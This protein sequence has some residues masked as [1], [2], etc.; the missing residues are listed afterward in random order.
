MNDNKDIPTLE[1]FEHVRS[2]IRS[3]GDYFKVHSAEQ[4][5]I[6]LQIIF[7][8]EQMLEETNLKACQIRRKLVDKFPGRTD[9]GIRYLV[10]KKF[11]DS[12]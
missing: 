3:L 4:E 2:E 9:G 12:E 1:D 7:E 8:Y 11:R 5:I 10:Y 6:D